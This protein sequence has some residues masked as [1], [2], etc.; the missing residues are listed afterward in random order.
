MPSY[1]A[2][3]KNL[4]FFCELLNCYALPVT[5]AQPRS[6]CYSL[7]DHMVFL[8]FSAL[9]NHNLLFNFKYQQERET[10]WAF[11]PNHVAL[12]Q[13]RK[14]CNGVFLHTWNWP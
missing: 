2:P 6:S 9:I 5:A 4:R 11:V 8:F 14:A 13:S 7:G 3:E 10:T 12:G 1:C